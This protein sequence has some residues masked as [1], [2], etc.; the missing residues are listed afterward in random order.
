M[1]NKAIKRDYYAGKI[2][3]NVSQCRFSRFKVNFIFYLSLFKFVLVFIPIRSTQHLSRS[4]AIKL[5]LTAVLY[6]Y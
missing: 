3:W 1:I 4:I 2:I 6:R 5:R